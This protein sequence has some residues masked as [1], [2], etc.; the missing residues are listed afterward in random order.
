MHLKL[1]IAC[2]VS[3]GVVNVSA[4]AH[5]AVDDIVAAADDSA[6]SHAASDDI[7]MLG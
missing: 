5:D 3:Y 7:L 2:H 6:V 4:A 1:L